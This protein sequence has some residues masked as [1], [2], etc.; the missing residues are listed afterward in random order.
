MSAYKQIEVHT[1]RSTPED[2]NLSK[3]SGSWLAYHIEYSIR[4][5][6]SQ[7]IQAD[8]DEP[9]ITVQTNSMYTIEDWYELTLLTGSADLEPASSSKND[10]AYERILALEQH[11]KDTN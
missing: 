11:L 2:G 6:I 10:I 9:T 1:N 7:R 5:L 4:A 3:Q 8:F